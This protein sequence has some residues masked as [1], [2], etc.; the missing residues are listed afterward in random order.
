MTYSSTYKLC[1][2]TLNWKRLIENWE[3]AIAHIH[4]LSILQ[5]N[6]VSCSEFLHIASFNWSSHL[7]FSW[8]P[9]LRTKSYHLLPK[10]TVL[11][12]TLRS[13]FWLFNKSTVR[14]SRLRTAPFESGSIL[15]ALAIGHLFVRS[16]TPRCQRG[17]LDFLY[18]I[19]VVSEDPKEIH[20]SR[21]TNIS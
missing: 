5:F 4:S 13:Y 6:F 15:T 11:L 18:S 7:D 17:S 9:R 10:S 8:S 14:N 21:K 12:I 3:F 20:F 16:A 1:M 19:F 2:W